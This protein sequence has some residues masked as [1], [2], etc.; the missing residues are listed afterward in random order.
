MAFGTNENSLKDTLMC[1]LFGI[2]HVV[3]P[4]QYIYFFLSIK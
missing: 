3:E 1:M 4:S 2:I